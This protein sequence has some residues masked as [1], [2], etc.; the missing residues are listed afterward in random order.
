MEYKSGPGVPPTAWG[1]QREGRLQFQATAPFHGS[2]QSRLDGANKPSD[3]LFPRKPD[4]QIP[5]V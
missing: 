5:P 2:G 3:L 4:I 1:R